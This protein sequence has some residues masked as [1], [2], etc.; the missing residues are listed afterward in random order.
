MEILTRRPAAT[1]VEAVVRRWFGLFK[2]GRIAEAEGMLDH[3]SVPHVLKALWTASCGA[4]E[5]RADEPRADEQDLSWLGELDIAGFSW[6][7]TG[8][9]CYV[10]I[11]HRGQVIEVALGFWAKPVDAGWVVSGPSTLW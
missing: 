1:D 10:E 2:A 8:T 9:N 11:T 4:D 7:T 3:A 6:G 5:P